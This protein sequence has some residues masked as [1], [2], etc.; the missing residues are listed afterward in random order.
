MA[1]IDLLIPKILKWEGGYSNIAEDRGGPTNLGITLENWK[2]YGYDKDGDGD[3]DVDD[4]KI[5]NVKDFKPFLKKLYWDRW[6][7]DLI[8]NQSV[9]DILVDWCYNSGAWGVKI[10]QK[11]L[12]TTIDGQAGPVTIGILNKQNQQSFFN[13][14][15]KA[16]QDFYNNI[17]KRS[18]EQKIFLKGWLARLNDYTFKP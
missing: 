12:G 7:A 17:V 10:P 16:R 5:L 2:L 8:A 13:Q 1:N 14:V 15:W 18:P 3:I 9:A 4:I 6:S 11:L